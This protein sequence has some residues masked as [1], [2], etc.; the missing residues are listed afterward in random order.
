MTLDDGYHVAVFIAQRREDFTMGDEAL[1]VAD[2]YSAFARGYAAAWSPVIRPLGQ[3]ML[4][5]LPW[6]RARRVLDLGTG[7]GA[8]LPDIRAAAPHAWILGADPS[9]GMLQLA[10]AH[11]VPLVVMDA[12]QLGIRATSID[13]VVMA[14]VL[15]HL[16]APEAALSDVRRALTPGGSLGTVTWAEDPELEATRVWEAELDAHGARDPAPVA[17]S[18]HTPTDTPEKMA[19]LFAQAGLDPVRIWIE[20]FEHRWDLDRF[21]AF[22]TTYGRTMRKLGSLDPAT[23]AAF[24]ERVRARL[25]A[26]D[27]GAFVYRAAV[28][29]GIA[30]RP[31]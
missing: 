11:A 4:A 18:D 23:H 8:L 14:F 10:R 28:V 22:R 16:G 20:R 27:A 26:L 2:A 5:G 1:K 3:R 21:T 15:F 12:M 7:T 30:R 31:R 13:V 6:E 9:T 19:A 25:S 24:L 29:C 17:S